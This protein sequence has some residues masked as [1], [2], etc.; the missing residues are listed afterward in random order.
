MKPTDQPTAYSYAP[1]TEGNWQ[2]LNEAFLRIAQ[3]NQALLQ[4]VDTLTKRV[5]TLE[6]PKP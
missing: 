3:A 1:I 2:E 6:K 4:M 5:E